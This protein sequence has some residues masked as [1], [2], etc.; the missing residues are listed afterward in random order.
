M[1]R[2]QE[3]VS[4]LNIGL[5]IFGLLLAYLIAVFVLYL[6][7][8]KV[9]GYQVVEGSLSSDNIYEGIALR[10]ETIATSPLAG[11]INYFAAEGSRVA[12][13]NL[14]YTVDES[15][16]L[17][18]YLQAQGAGNF[19]LSE[20]DL[21][22]LRT[23]IVNF[24][25]SFDRKEF[26][27]VYEFKNGLSGTINKLSNAGILNNIESLNET[28][29]SQ[30]I[31]YCRAEDT[32]IVIYS[33]DGFESLRA[34]EITADTF[35]HESYEKHQLS[36]NALVEAGD[37][38]YKL[39]TDD[40][41]SIV[42]PVSDKT[43]DLLEELSY[44]RVR[45]LKNQDVSWAGTRKFS[46]EE[47]NTFVELSF[48]NSMHAFCTERFINIELLLSEDTGLKIPV[49]AI[50]NRR[51]YLIPKDFI[52]TNDDG[53][54]SVLRRS[55]LENGTESA[56]MVDAEIYNET[57]TMYSLDEMTVEAG[58]VLLK[59][60]SGETFTVSAQ[61][62]L[63][64]VYN[65]NKGYADFKQ[66][67]VLYENEEYAIVESNTRYGLTAYDYIVLDAESVQE[68]DMIYN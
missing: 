49:S 41:W 35:L 68:N 17:L 7:T 44:V 10:N 57:E 6:R 26:H 25:S 8:D 2:K 9:R 5:I 38:V 4:H 29:A 27:T 47:G 28:S 22:E 32:G 55:Y 48:N 33:T 36:S 42:I 21:T 30:T 14:V 16:N 62:S 67:N 43:G 58:D 39:C 15:G 34:S 59:E 46:D 23:Q 19:S 40:N 54:T 45:F 1:A 11:Y 61:E 31:Q 24:S 60:G 12:V 37:A 3:R 63:T 66:I 51:F 56:E 18:D 13:G 52:I 20:S 53:T 50:V 65:I 64:G